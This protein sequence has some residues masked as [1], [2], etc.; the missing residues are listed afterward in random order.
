MDR[1]EQAYVKIRTTDP[2]GTTAN[3]TELCKSIVW[4]G[5]WRNASRTLSFSP[6]FS[7]V[8]PHLP[9]APTEL[10][11]S[12]QF[13]RGSDL[14]MDAYSLER[15]RDSLGTTID[16][17]AYDRSLYLKRNS[18]FMR[19]E[20]QTAE[21]VTA[22]LCGQFGIQ[23]GALAATGAPLTRNFLGV[24]LYKIIMTL[25][26]LASDQTGKK[27][28]IRFKGPKLEVV[29]MQK[30]P[31]TII[32]KPGCN[33]LSCTTKESASAM[34]NSVAIYDEEMN[35]V[36]AEED[37]EAVRLYGLMQEAIKAGAYDD[38]A[39]HARQILKENGMK[40][41]ITLRCLGNLKLITGNTVAV[42]EPVTGIS[43]LFWIVSDQHTWKNGVYTT[44]LTVDLE[45]L[46]DEQ[47]AGS[48]PT[49]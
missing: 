48:L 49:K 36:G 8:D 15:T 22:S 28:R 10:G 11:G 43:G 13:W 31:D 21:A 20:G 4:K 17:T 26:T 40:T 9:K 44:Q 42:R 16:V 39:G 24:N 2:D 35:R 30:T 7:D 5:D 45:A 14:L 41:T 1:P 23:T 37:G 27:Y 18:T 32:L 6:V 29:E 3:I 46:M 19:V 34:V 47:T 33:L 25:Y 12:C 38:P